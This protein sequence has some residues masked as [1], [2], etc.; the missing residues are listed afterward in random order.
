MTDRASAEWISGFW[1]RIGAFAIDT[2]ALIEHP[3]VTYVVVSSGTS[4]RTSNGVLIKTTTY[5]GARTFLKNDTVSDVEL[6]EQLATILALNHSN[7]Q[8]MDVIQ[9][10]LTYGYDIGIASSWSSYSHAFSPPDLMNEN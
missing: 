1:R 4:T 3:S 8:Q 10:V 9:I 6:A 7:A 2:T 5:L